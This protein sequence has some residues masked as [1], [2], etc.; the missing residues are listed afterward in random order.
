MGIFIKKPFLWAA[1]AAALI[2]LVSGFLGGCD[3]GTNGGGFVPVTKITGP[4]AAIKGEPLTLAGTVEPANATNRTIVWS[5]TGVS[6][7]VLTATS[8]PVT[9]YAVIENGTAPSV[10]YTETITIEVVDAG[11][12]PNDGTNPFGTDAVPC[13]WAKDGKDGK[14]ERAYVKITGTTTGGSW[15]AIEDGEP[16][17]NGTYTRIGGTAIKWNV[18]GGR[19][20]GD[21]G[22][23]YID[24][25]KMNVVNFTDEYSG[26][27]GT[28]TK[29]DTDLTLEGSWQT[30]DPVM[31]GNYLKIVA[32]ND[33]TFYMTDGG[34][35][36]GVWGTYTGA[37]APDTN[38]A[39]CTIDEVNINIFLGKPGEVRAAWEALTP[40]Q[41]N[42]FGGHKI[43]TVIVYADRC[44]YGGFVLNKL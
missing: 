8:G 21:T 6:G 32:E 41:K 16:Y 30:G 26:M 25:G 38:P 5:G 19:H 23:A 36:E 4:A 18:T 39:V 37:H 29:L 3:T 1:P 2:M 24:G 12:N 13:L 33:G 35:R 9:V 31:H 28:Y 27:N 40:Q 22:L 43:F 42:Y 34:T 20:G 15:E 11:T 44:E 17:N 10:P 14:G 7:G